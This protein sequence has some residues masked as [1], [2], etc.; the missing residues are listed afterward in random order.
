[1]DSAGVIRMWNRAF[2]PTWVQVANT[3][4]HVSNTLYITETLNTF[5]FTVITHRTYGNGPF[6]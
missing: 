3:T 1:M 2:G 6:M 5:L 4:D